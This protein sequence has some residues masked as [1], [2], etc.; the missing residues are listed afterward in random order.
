VKTGRLFAAAPVVTVATFAL[1]IA[2]G[3]VGTLAPAFGYLP[4][5]GGHEFS[6]S[7]WRELF[8]WPGFASSVRL[9]LVTGAAT[10]ISACC[11]RV[12]AWAAG[13]AWGPRAAW[14]APILD[15][16]LGF[17]R[18]RVRDRAVGSCEALAMAHRLRR[19]ARCRDDRPPATRLV[20]GM[21]VKGSALPRVDDD[22]AL[23]QVRA[24]EHL[25]VA[26]SMGT[27]PPRVGARV[28]YRGVVAAG[29]MPFLACSYSLS[30]VDVAIL[31]PS[32]PPTLAVLAY[33]SA[34]PTCACG[35]RRRGA[36]LQLVI[37]A[38]SMR[39]DRARAHDRARGPARRQAGRRAALSTLSSFAA[40]GV[41][42]LALAVAAMTS[43]ATWSV[44][45]Q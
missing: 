26:R 45:S 40:A 9:T 37:V 22:C 31:G 35:S 3:F 36:S 29:A 42:S 1:P 34:I 32:S 30:V 19:A 12:C 10:L 14:L 7:A 2:A 27:D 6:L 5:I 4:A 44:A 17:P 16:A 8:A 28:C 43:M 15:A 39:V 38:A 41:A 18:P 23:A 20:L 24:T 13:R 21:V 33:G 25:A 11:V